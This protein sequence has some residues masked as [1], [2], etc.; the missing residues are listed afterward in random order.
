[1]PLKPKWIR[2]RTYQRIRN[3]IQAFE[4]KA[5]ARRFKKPGDRQVRQIDAKG[6]VVVV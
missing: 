2:R 6:D 5:K 3:E 4:A 1:M